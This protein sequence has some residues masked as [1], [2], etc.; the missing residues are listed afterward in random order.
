VY[1]YGDH[2]PNIF[3]RKGQDPAGA[4]PDFDY[5]VL[6][7]E[8]LLE[9]LAYTDGKLRL[10]SGMSY[11]V[12]VLPDHRVLSLGVLKKIDSLVRAGATVLG[13][14]P[15]K[16][17][18]LEG[19]GEGKALFNRIA[20]ELWVTLGAIA[21]K[22]VRQ[23]GSG[24]VA[25]GMTARELLHDDGIAPDVAVTLK[26][27]TNAPDTDWIHYRDGDAEVYFLAELAGKARSVEATFRVEGRIPELWDAVDGSIRE[28]ATYS[29]A[30]GVTRLPL[31]LGVY[32]SLFVVFRKT[33]PATERSTGPNSPAWQQAQT[34]GGPWDVTF[35][36]KWGG[37]AKPVRFEK[38]SD[39]IKHED[40]AIRF[41]SG[42][43]T[44][45]TRFTIGADL[46]GKALALELGDV[47]DVGMARVK[48][49]GTDLGIVWRP[50]FRVNLGK[51]VKAGENTLEVMVVNSWRNRLIGDAALPE[52]QRLTKTNVS[53]VMNG[54]GKWPLEPSGLLGPVTLVSQ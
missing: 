15:I 51:F 30:G 42:K 43:A 23:V 18:S 5:D 39:W 17:V 40:P 32:D 49:N 44:Y 8:L 21:P 25:W 27:G 45:Q 37:P 48:L 19:G 11:R 36:S 7:E 24:R 46:A 34:I 6:S 16:A 29:S 52:D 22:G 2:I 33:T 1:Y 47:K 50:P 31:E 26:D 13:P 35:D 28:A 14:K 41:Y 20:D 38:L 4:L 53:V 10:P 3:G 54:P 9:K 12:L